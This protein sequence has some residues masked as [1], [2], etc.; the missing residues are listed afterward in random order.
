QAAETPDAV[1]VLFEGQQLNY[2]E[3]NVRAN[4]LA[5]Y[6]RQL[7]VGPEVLVGI[8]LERSLELVI[9][10]LGILKAGGA[11]LPL[12]PTYPSERVQFMIED[13]GAHVLLT[14]EKRLSARVNPIIENLKSKIQNPRVIYLDT[15]NSDIDNASWNNVDYDVCS[16]DLA[17]VIYTSGSTGQPKGVMVSHRALLN[18]M[19]WMQ[20][21]FGFGPDDAIVQKTPISFDA[22]V[23]ELFAPLISGGR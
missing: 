8:Y 17:Y 14:Q 1:A 19:T 4:Q 6:L 18:H 12:D 20:Q 16:N 22:S 23:W 11:Y 13:S 21:R 9:A 3:L 7:G 5:H 2:R 15:E 10:L